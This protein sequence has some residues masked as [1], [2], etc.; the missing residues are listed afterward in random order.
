[1]AV[2]TFE[3]F[4]LIAYQHTLVIRTEATN[5]CKQF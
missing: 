1:M 3:K 5:I 2:T 4:G